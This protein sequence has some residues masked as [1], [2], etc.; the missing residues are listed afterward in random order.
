[1]GSGLS[2]GGKFYSCTDD[3]SRIMTPCFVT[4]TITG[5]VTIP[6]GGENRRKIIRLSLFCEHGKSVIL[7]SRTNFIWRVVICSLSGDRET[8]FGDCNRWIQ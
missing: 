3:G 5:N 4:K 1:M 2:I 7:F 6:R 8:L